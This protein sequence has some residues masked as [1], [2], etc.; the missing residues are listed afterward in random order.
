MTYHFKKGKKIEGWGV[1]H[2]FIVI[3]TD[4]LDMLEKLVKSDAIL[5]K[6]EIIDISYNNL[7]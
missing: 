5:Q 6:Q 1:W 4:I 3:T 7:F 2:T